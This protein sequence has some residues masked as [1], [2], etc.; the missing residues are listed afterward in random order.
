VPDSMEAL[1]ALP[2]VGRKTANL[3][4]ATSFT[5]PRSWSTRTASASPIAW[6]WWDGLQ[7]PVK[8]ERALRELLPPTSPPTF[9]IVWYC[10][11]GPSAAP[12][13]H[14]APAA[15]ARPFARQ[16]IPR[17]GFARRYLPRPRRRGRRP[18]RYCRTSRTAFATINPKVT[19]HF[20][21]E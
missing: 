19:G 17:R 1:L 11:G 15:A 6:G 16:S 7:D 10:T 12:A 9:V 2:G 20:C 5:S 13:P 4:W 21:C 18:L 14:C 3:I 8:I